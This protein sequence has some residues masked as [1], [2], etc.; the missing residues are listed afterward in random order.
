MDST[1]I[2]NKQNN[3]VKYVILLSID[4]TPSVLLHVYH[5]LHPMLH[6]TIHSKEHPPIDI[7]KIDCNW[8]TELIDG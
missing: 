3:Y 2:N 7:C 4:S 8:M 6:R 1:M 5:N